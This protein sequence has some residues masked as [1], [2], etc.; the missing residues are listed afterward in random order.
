M[1]DNFKKEARVKKSNGFTCKYSMP[2]YGDVLFIK[3][4][5]D[6]FSTVFKEFCAITFKDGALQFDSTT[7]EAYFKQLKSHQTFENPYKMNVKN[8][9]HDVCSTACMMY[10]KEYDIFYI[11][12]GFQEFLFAEYYTQAD[13]E[14]GE[15]LVEEIFQDQ[16]F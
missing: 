7:F 6:Q 8:F 16:V 4:Y 10:E 3:E 15:P 11:D 13:L 14:G 1:P 2:Q 12:P 5:V 9:K